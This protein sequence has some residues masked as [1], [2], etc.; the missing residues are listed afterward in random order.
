[1][2]TV[3]EDFPNQ[4]ARARELLAAYKEIGA[5]GRFGAAVIERAL[6][7]A[8]EAAISGDVVAILAAYNELKS[9]S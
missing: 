3:G 8:D 9:L 1:M 4:Q 2:T 7:R 6:K 5:A